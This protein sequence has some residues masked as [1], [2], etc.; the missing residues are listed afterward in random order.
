V[1]IAAV[2]LPAAIASRNAV[3]IVSWVS[4]AFLQLV[5]LSVVGQIVLVSSCEVRAE[6]T[7]QDAGALLHEAV[8]IQDHLVVQDRVLV[9]LLRMLE[10]QDARGWSS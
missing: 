6:A 7:Y 4:Q 5:L 3:I 8:K 1:A 2:S 10:S 9:S